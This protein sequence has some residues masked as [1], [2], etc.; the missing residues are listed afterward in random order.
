MTV[1]LPKAAKNVVREKVWRIIRGLPQGFT[2]DEV[3]MLTESPQGAVTTYLIML[4]DAGYIRRSGKRKEAPC[5]VKHV[6]R[7]AKNTGP[8]APAPCRCLY[9]PN[10]D[11]TAPV[12]VGTKPGGGSHVD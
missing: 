7:L 3:A 6:W 4:A 2:F 9:D 1:M 8:K 12:G 5:R 10:I 11:N